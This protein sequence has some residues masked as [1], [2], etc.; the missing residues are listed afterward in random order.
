LPAAVSTEGAPASGAADA[1][2]EDEMAAGAATGSREFVTGNAAKGAA[3]S[4]CTGAWPTF[5][6]AVG[7]LAKIPPSDA[8]DPRA[9]D[10]IAAGAAAGSRAFVTGKA[11]KG[12]ALSL[13][14]GA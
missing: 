14:T 10:W 3:L 9:E 1:G 8:A 7:A 12:A 13:C 2:K 4:L 11:A 6:D 5:V